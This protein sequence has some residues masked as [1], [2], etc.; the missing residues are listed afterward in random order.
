MPYSWENRLKISIFG[1]SHEK[2]IGVELSGIPAR[3]RIDYVALQAF[4]RR[5][6]PGYSEYTTARREPDI[7]VITSGIAGGVTDGGTIRIVIENRD[8]VSADY[9]ELSDCPRPGHADYTAW[10]KYG[11]R[12]DM[13]G[14]GAFSGRMTAPLCAAGGVCLQILKRRNINISAHI[15]RIGDISDTPYDPMRGATE[16]CGEFPCV[17][18]EAV[19]LMKS[20]ILAAAAE[21]DSLGAVIECAADGVPAGL[22][23]PLFEGLEGRIAS[24]AFAIPAVKGIEFGAG[25]DAA[26]LRGSENNDPFVICGGCVA[27]AT[28]NA[29]GILGGISDGMP[30]VFRAAIKP[31]PSIAKAQRSVSLRDMTE[32]E[33]KIGGRH[34]PC[35]APRAVPV[36]EAAAAIALL[37]ALLEDEYER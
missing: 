15:L 29:G 16:A 19:G 35:I 13:R 30:L 10:V 34:D 8:A 36:V 28:N 14:G 32:R 4:M 23:G 31:T 11:G 22:G 9:K 25:F 1:R 2:E 27:T 26:R 6:A 37:D 24:L 18:P 17:S 3:E 7:P 21:G 20:S 12:E 33:L 5:R